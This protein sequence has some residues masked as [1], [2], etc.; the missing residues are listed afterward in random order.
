MSFIARLR[1]DLEQVLFPSRDRHAIPS[2]D[3]PLSPNDILDAAVPAG[4][5]LPGADDIVACGDG[6][7]LVAAGCEIHRLSGPGL[8]HSA[9]FRR[10]ER[11]VTA[12]ARHP[13]GRVLA[14]TAGEGLWAV[15][16]DGTCRG[17]AQAGGMPLTGITAIVAGPDGTIFAAQGSRRF[18]PDDFLHDLMHRNRAGALAAIAPDLAA[19][20]VIADGLAFP[21]GLCL[22]AGG[23]DLLFTQAW[24]HSLHRIAPTG[25][26]AT[27][28]I[29]NL[30]GYPGRIAAAPDGYLLCLFAMRTHLTE[31]VLRE[32]DFR[33]EMMARIDPA[34]WIGPALSTTGSCY[35]PLQAGNV[36]KLGVMKPWAPPRS[37]G[38]VVELDRTG[39][40]RRAMHSRAGGNWH[41]ITAAVATGD[42]LVVVSKGAG[43]ILQARWEEE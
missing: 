5:A 14:A 3:G 15:A 40:P 28:V 37:Y 33:R 41:G 7:V 29:P 4:P 30:P 21:A 16:P 18:A 1:R 11:T 25:G 20:R 26:A 19:G 43:R 17:L 35:E 36:K 32:D 42:G 8:D 2:M 13:D 24:T 27:A 9:L 39:E 23:R 12:I 38:L 34:Y 6:S 22:D 10:F 31:L